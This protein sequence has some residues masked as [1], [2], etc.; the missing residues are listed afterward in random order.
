VPDGTVQFKADGV[1]LAAP[2]A[3]DA[4]GVAAFVTNSL[5]HG[6]NTISAEYAGDTNGDFQGLTNRIVQVVNTPPAS[7]NSTASVMA[8]QTLVLS[9]AKLLARASDADA[10]DTLS[11]VAAGPT[12]TNGSAGNV[13]LDG[14]AGTVAYTPASG[15]AG[16]DSFT[17][18]ISDNYGGT[19]TPTVYVTVTSA[20]GGS[21]NVVSGPTYANGTFSV[22]FAGIPNLTYTVQYA[23][24]PSGPWTFLGTATAGTNGL[25]EVTDTQSLPPPARYYRTVYP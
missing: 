19:V 6:S 22:T 1:A 14:G 9:V 23:T 20:S 21:P 7:P 18:T 11:I 17:Y 4:N 5:P 13:V 8:N 15:Y 12:S 10:G 3:L 24:D 2:V 16:P 25:F